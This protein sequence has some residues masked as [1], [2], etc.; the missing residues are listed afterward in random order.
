[1]I[2]TELVHFSLVLI[3]DRLLHGRVV[4]HWIPKL[5]PRRIAIVDDSLA[6]D[7]D[8]LSLFEAVAPNDIALWIGPV[9]EAQKALLMNPS[10]PPGS[11][12]VLVPSPKMAR[13]LFDAGI[14]YASLN[15]GCLVQ[16]KGQR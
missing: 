8:A 3:D 5:R 7:S 14:H 12:P 11:T 15:V 10:F 4:L 13:A 16:Q 9:G 1:M 6:G 2:E